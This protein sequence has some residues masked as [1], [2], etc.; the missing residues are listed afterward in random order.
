ME[1]QTSSPLTGENSLLQKLSVS[2]KVT[3]RIYRN[4]VV[5]VVLDLGL[6]TESYTEVALCWQKLG[7]F[8]VLGVFGCNACGILAS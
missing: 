2:Q 4:T 1:T 8:Y 3:P 7:F 6:L 5:T